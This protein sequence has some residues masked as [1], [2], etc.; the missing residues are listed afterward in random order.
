MRGDLDAVHADLLA[1][2]LVV[3]VDESRLRRGGGNDERQE[4]E[5]EPG[6]GEGAGHQ[7]NA[8][9]GARASIDHNPDVTE[10]KNE[11]VICNVFPLYQPKTYSLNLDTNEASTRGA[12][13]AWKGGSTS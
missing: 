7:G 10:W 1:A 8:P 3:A 12:L 6:E 5:Q 4:K 2:R 13:L 9:A 11:A